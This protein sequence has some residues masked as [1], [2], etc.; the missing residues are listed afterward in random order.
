M[1]LSSRLCPDRESGRTCPIL[2]SDRD[3]PEYC[4]RVHLND[5][6][7]SRDSRPLSIVW[8]FTKSRLPSL[9]GQCNDY[10][11][12]P[13]FPSYIKLHGWFPCAQPPFR[14]LSFFLQAWCFQYSTSSL[15]PLSFFIS[16]PWFNLLSRLSLQP[17]FPFRLPRSLR[18]ELLRLLQ[19]L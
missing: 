10:C 18:S 15:L 16:S 9:Y 11:N 2:T 17:S 8:T 14:L 13:L 5:P 7:R 12:P 6:G 3:R 1:D 4:Y 19:T